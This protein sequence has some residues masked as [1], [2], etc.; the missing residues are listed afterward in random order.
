MQKKK[1]VTI[2]LSV[3]MFLAIAV[4]GFA[5]VFRIDSVSLVSTTISSQAED[6]AEQ[7]Q[8]E[9]NIC[10]IGQN[11]LFADQSAANEAIVNFPYFRITAFRKEF[12]NRLVIE[13]QEDEE[14]FAVETGT[15][16]YVLGGDGMMLGRRNTLENRSG[17]YPNIRVVGLTLEYNVGHVVTGNSLVDGFVSI[18]KTMASVQGMGGNLRSNVA[19]ITIA[20]SREMRIQ[21]KEGVLVRVYNFDEN[22]QA[23]AELLVNKYLGLQDFQKVTGTIQVGDTVNGLVA[24]YYAN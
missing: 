8:S 10:Y 19:E 4:L 16:Y 14:M 11:T 3:M 24:E 20:N 21:M 13:V 7:L 9:L 22:P 6:E 15:D 2:L 5:N 23:K 1:F 18:V 17:N 12:P